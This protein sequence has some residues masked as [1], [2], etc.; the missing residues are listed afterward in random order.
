EDAV[1]AEPS[2]EVPERA[3]RSRRAHRKAR[4][5]CGDLRHVR[6]IQNLIHVQRTCFRLSFWRGLHAALPSG[7]AAVARS[8]GAVRDRSELVEI[9]TALHALAPA[10]DLVLAAY[11]AGHRVPAG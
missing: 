4:S 3:W 7:R 10:L 6:P 2:A 11:V 8:H 9:G 5:R 1:R